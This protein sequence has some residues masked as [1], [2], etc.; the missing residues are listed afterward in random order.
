MKKVW[1]LSIVTILLGLCIDM[2]FRYHCI[3]RGI[4][5]IHTIEDIRR[6]DCNVNQMFTKDNVD[7]FI[8]SGK[9]WF[10]QSHEGVD[11]Y[12]VRPANRLDQYSDTMLQEVEIVQV[13]QGT[14]EE[15]DTIKIVTVGGIYDQIYHPRDDFDND[16]PLFRGMR[17][18]L[19]S[20]NQYLVFLEPLTLNKY[21]KMKQ[22]R[23]ADS[24][25]GSFNITSDYSTPIDKQVY[26]IAYNDFGDSEFLCDTPETL[27]K[28]LEFKHS[29]LEEYNIDNIIQR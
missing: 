11:I 1:I 6:L 8:A 25:F 28:L 29:I 16:R 9:K 22:Y 7:G 26:T 10:S 21:T 27:E 19:F 12:I 20:D 13:I 5:D 23:F 4:M 14:G 17:N 3:D 2:V 15:S 24:L 18:L